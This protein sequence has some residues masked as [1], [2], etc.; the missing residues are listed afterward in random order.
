VGLSVSPLREPDYQTPRGAVII[1]RDLT[2]IRELEQKV[3]VN[4][5]FAALG[6]LSAGVAHEIRNP[7]NSI[8]GFIQYFQRKLP[9]EEEDYNYT[10]LMLTEVDRL[11]R[12]ISKLLA[13]S[14]P[15]E[16]RLGIRSVDEALDHCV[17]VVKREAAESGVEIVKEAQGCDEPPL[18]LMD[19]DQMT[20]VFMNIMINAIEASPRGGR[21]LI[22]YHCEES[23]RVHITIS[24][25]G[26]GIPVENMDKLFDP[27]FTTK[28]KGTGLGLAIV[29]S[30]I[31][32]HG[33]EIEIES[34]SQGGAKFIISLS[35]YDKDLYQTTKDSTSGDNIPEADWAAPRADSTGQ[36]S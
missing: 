4:E 28:R 26:D 23:G 14:K 1:V 11:N 21:V 34:D 35:L 30:I 36:N 15:R 24:D 2:I 7:L 33:G 20:Q 8:R 5:K 6:R 16:P 25:Q 22:G 32:G 29:K 3:V 27:F 12:V 10:E 19:T 18:A 17:R 31:E 13:Y 9:M